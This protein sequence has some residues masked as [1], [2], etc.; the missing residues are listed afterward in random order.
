MITSIEKDQLMTRVD[1]ALDDIRPHLEVDGGNIELVDI[2]DDMTVLVKWVGNCVNCSMS[3]MTMK[4]GV[5]QVVKAQVPE[6]SR[7]QAVNGENLS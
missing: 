6:V 3:L 5:E 1:K 2:L 7:I 4:A